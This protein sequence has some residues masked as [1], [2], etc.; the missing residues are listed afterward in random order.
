MQR[1]EFWPVPT[2]HRAYWERHNCALVY[3]Y[4]STDDGLEVEVLKAI[5]ATHDSLD[6][7]IE[8]QDCFLYRLLKSIRKSLNE[9]EPGLSS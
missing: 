7:A 9:F 8:R 1:S 6:V 3:E 4:D 2:V 5:H